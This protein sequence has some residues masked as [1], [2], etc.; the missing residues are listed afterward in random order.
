MTVKDIHNVYC[1]DVVTTPRTSSA[2]PAAKKSAKPAK[3]A[4]EKPA[5]KAGSTRK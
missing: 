2:K 5:G 4:V 1:M 3:S